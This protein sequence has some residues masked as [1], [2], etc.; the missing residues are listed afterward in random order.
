MFSKVANASKVAFIHWSQHLKANN[1]KLL[2]CQIYNP[3]LES[4]GCREIARDEFLEI[5]KN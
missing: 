2:D 4:L 1:Y 3:H 5:L